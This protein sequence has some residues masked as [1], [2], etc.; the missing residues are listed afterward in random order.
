M[1]QR[2]RVFDKNSRA[3]M[4][5]RFSVVQCLLQD[6]PSWG[7]NVLEQ[8]GE[9]RWRVWLMRRQRWGLWASCIYPDTTERFIAFAPIGKRAFL[10]YEI[11]KI[12]EDHIQ[13]MPIGYLPKKLI[14][15]SLM[16]L[17]L[18]MVIPVLLAPIVWRLSETSTLCY[19]R[20][21]LDVFCR[22]VQTK[23]MNSTLSLKSG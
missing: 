1:D 6:E 18:L 7:A 4:V 8:A 12:D 9:Y 16:F 17:L 10:A 14:A 3:E 13:V 19:S 11:S 22:M 23:L 21:Y 15:A 2:Y 20:L 5:A